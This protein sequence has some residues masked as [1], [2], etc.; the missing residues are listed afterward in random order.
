MKPSFL[1]KNST[2]YQI[3]E[4]APCIIYPWSPDYLRNTSLCLEDATACCSFCVS[5]TDCVSDVGPAS[6]IVGNLVQ[7]NRLASAQ[8]R[9]MG[10]LDDDGD[11]SKKVSS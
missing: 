6:V 4:V 2:K 11:S 3:S 5:A 7:G 9:D 1:L 8:G 10:L